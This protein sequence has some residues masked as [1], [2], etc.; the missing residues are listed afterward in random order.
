M[1]TPILLAV[2]AACLASCPSRPAAAQGAAEPL[3]SVDRDRREVR[4]ACQALR[5]D[6]R[7]EFFCVGVGGPDHETVLRTKVRPAEIH[8]ALLGLGVEPGQPLRNV[9]GTRQF[10]PPSGPPI[11]VEVEWQQDGRLVRERAGRLIRDVRT[12]RPMP[13]Q[14]FVFVGSKFTDDGQYAADLT[15][16]V[17][18][19]VN[20]E[21]TTIDVPRLASNANETLEWETNPDVAPPAGTPVTMILTALAAD[22]VPATEPATRPATNP[23]TNPT[24][25]PGDDAESRLATLRRA[26]EQSVLPQGAALRRA[27]QTH[28]EVM[29]AYQD[30]INE[31]LDE[32]ERLRREM[33]ALQ[34]RYNELT[35]PQP[36]PQPAPATR[37]AE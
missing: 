21:F 3:L 6:M 25:Q 19:L 1:K 2:L 16:Q 24:T 4:V 20:F 18:S 15:G 31:K 36:I 26:W 27:A 8:A 9:P 14:P 22:A 5:V 33:D 10:L 37:P 12:G 11:R 29:R 7:L 35:T 28:Y 32:V 17:V 13:N 30:E 23:A 34:E